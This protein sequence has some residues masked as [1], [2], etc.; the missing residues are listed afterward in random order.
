MD[1]KLFDLGVTHCVPWW[2]GKDWWLHVESDNS[3]DFDECLESSS[4]FFSDTGNQFSMSH[5]QAE[6][7]QY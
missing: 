4:I 2:L 7:Q 1:I 5:L 3:H 6:L